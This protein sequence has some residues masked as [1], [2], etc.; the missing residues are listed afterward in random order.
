M[1]DI[2]TKENIYISATTAV[3]KQKSNKDNAESQL[4]NI[5]N[6][7]LQNVVQT[8]LHKEKLKRKKDL[9]TNLVT[10]GGSALLAILLLLI[11]IVVGILFIIVVGLVFFALNQNNDEKTAKYNNRREFF[12]KYAK[13]VPANENLKWKTGSITYSGTTTPVS[14]TG[15]W[16]CPQCSTQNTSGSNFCVSCGTKKP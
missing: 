6:V 12:A 15:G 3:E 11:N 1:N 5:K 9:L 8:A 7:Y 16:S 14:Q 4:L 13:S 10:Y 2:Q